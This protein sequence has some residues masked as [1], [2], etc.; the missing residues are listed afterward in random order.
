MLSKCM[1]FSQ[2]RA[3]Y[4]IILFIQRNPSTGP[5]HFKNE[6]ITVLTDGPDTP[7]QLLPTKANIVS[8]VTPPSEDYAEPFYRTRKGRLVHSWAGPR[9]AISA[10]YSVR[11]RSFQ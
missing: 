2:V 11:R 1:T 8:M 7:R 9:L 4:D 10:S 3:A 5:L 6:D